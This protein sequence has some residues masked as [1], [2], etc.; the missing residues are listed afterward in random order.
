VAADERT[1]GEIAIAGGRNSIQA[2]F[3]GRAINA[4]DTLGNTALHYAARMG[5]PEAVQLLLDL[6][7]D[8]DTR[9]ISA[10]RPADIAM[11]WNNHENARVLN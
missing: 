11:R 5:R 6:G 9:N 7:A 2:V 4:K 10:E 1:P 3:S 8:K